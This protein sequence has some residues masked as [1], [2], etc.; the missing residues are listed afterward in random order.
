MKKWIIICIALMLVFGALS[1]P[2]LPLGLDKDSADDEE[3]K[4]EEP[5]VTTAFVMVDPDSKDYIHSCGATISFHNVVDDVFEYITIDTRAV[6]ELAPNEYW[7][8][9]VDT[10][11][12]Y[13][14]LYA[15]GTRTETKYG[16]VDT[17]FTLGVGD[18]LV[19]FTDY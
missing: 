18:T 13:Y 6:G 8:D 12:Q 14:I 15:D 17:H 4:V 2:F 1:I 7:F 5:E 3:D 16:A 19:I 11:V 10:D 9:G